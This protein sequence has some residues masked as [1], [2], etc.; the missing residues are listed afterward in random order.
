M[1][2]VLVAALGGLYLFLQVGSLQEEEA[3]LEGQLADTRDAIESLTEEEANL[4]E[5]L[6][7]V[8]SESEPQTFVPRGDAESV[9]TALA[10]YVAENDLR[11]STF[12]ATESLVPLGGSN[13]PAITYTLVAEGAA[14]LLVGMLNLID[15][16][17]TALVESLELVRDVESGGR[18]EMSL[19]L[20]VF[21]S[22]QASDGL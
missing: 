9:G 4:E 2:L 21:Y 8:E 7:Q 6:T 22:T 11:L 1:G 16:V 18:W 5:E 14:D 20:V 10:T 13:E 3:E 15:V 19:G 12:D 17:P